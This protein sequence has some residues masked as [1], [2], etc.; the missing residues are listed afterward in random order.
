MTPKTV[1]ASLN[2]DLERMRI[3]ADRW[4]VNVEPSKCKALTISRKWN[5]T[6][7][8]L[9]LGNTKLAEKEEL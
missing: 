6:R 9:M 5:P 1:T 7:L 2:R 8:D 4:K 3:W